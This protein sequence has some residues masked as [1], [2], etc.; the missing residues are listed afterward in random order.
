MKKLFLLFVISS[1]IERE[2]FRCSA[3]DENITQRAYEIVTCRLLN[4]CFT[5]ELP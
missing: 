1:E 3:I 4:E 2:D 5:T